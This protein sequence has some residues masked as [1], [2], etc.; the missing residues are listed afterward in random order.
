M[1]IADLEAVA[2]DKLYEFAFFGACLRLRGA[3]GCVRSS[4][5]SGDSRAN[6]KG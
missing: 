3:T 6:L 2:A 4:C 1:E 5:R